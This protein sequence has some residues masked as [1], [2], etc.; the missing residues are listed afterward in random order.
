MNEFVED[1]LGRLKHVGLGRN[2]D[3][4][5]PFLSKLEGL[6]NRFP[7]MRFGQLVEN[8]LS[9]YVREKHG[10]YNRNVFNALLWNLEEDEWEEAIKLFGKEFSND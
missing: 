8:V 1:Y 7:D 9:V 3:R 4:I 6:W 5:Y 2:P 10:E